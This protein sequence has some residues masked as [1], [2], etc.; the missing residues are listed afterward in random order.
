[1]TDR[2]TLDQMTSDDLDDLHDELARLRAGEEDGWDPL[3]APT[4]GQ[5]IARW[6]SLHP[7]ERLQ[8]AQA[9][10]RD[11]DTARHCRFEGHQEQLVMDNKAWLRLARVRDVI[12]DM[13]QITGARQWARILRRA[14]DGEEPAPAPAGT[15]ETGGEKTTRIFAALHRSAEQDVTRV[16]NLY[17]HWVKAGP[18]PLGTPIA[19][20]WDNRLVELHD[21]IV[22]QPA[23]TTPDNPAA[24]SLAGAEETEH[25][26]LSTAC[27]HNEH[28][29][30]QADTGLSG[31]KTPAQCKFCA[32]PCQCACHASQT[33]EA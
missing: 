3:A 2:K 16:I 9:I 11:A 33:K 15:E 10:I 26:Y 27:L 5:W 14:V 12:A 20:W 18:P 8:W 32:A 24:S 21:A 25:R 28:G 6:N 22:E 17:E 30:C 31:T 13:E 19:R 23:R 29:Y 7:S 1:M 4:P